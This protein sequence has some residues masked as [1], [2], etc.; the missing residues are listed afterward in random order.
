[1]TAKAP[2]ILVVMAD[3]L[4]PAFLPI[5]GHPLVRAPNLEALASDGVVF[6]SAY[7]ASLCARPRAPS[8]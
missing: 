5:Y 6:D 3:Q 2:N 8:S 4:A 1:M 7:C